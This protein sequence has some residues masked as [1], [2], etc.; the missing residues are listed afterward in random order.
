MRAAV[1][2]AFGRRPRRNSIFAR[3]VAALHVSRRIEARRLLRRYRHLISEDFQSQPNSISPA[4][5]RERESRENA[6]R[7]NARVSADHR[8]FENA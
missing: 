4:A 7:N 8:E 2:P 3:I 5:G 6:N 1:Q